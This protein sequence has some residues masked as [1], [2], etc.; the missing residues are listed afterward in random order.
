MRIQLRNRF[1]VADAEAFSLAEGRVGMT[2]MR[3]HAEPPESLARGTLSQGF[4]RNLGDLSPPPV[5]GM[6]PPD[7]NGP[8]HRQQGC[9][10]WWSEEASHGGT[11][12]QGRPETSGTGKEESYEP[13][14]PMKVGNRRAT[15]TPVAA[16]I[17]TRGKGGTNRRS[18]RGTHVGTPMPERYTCQTILDRLTELAREIT[19]PWTGAGSSV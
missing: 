12:R 5:A 8:G 14:V 13:I 19:H 1:A 16:T 7:R 10:A 18:G 6:V 15:R 4:P 17:P 2:V 11:G 3:G 9:A